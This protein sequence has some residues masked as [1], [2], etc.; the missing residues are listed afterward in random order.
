MT[1]PPTPVICACSLPLSQSPLE[2]SLINEVHPRIAHV[3]VCWFI[4]GPSPAAP[5]RQST[6][7]ARAA[8]IWASRY[9]HN[10]AFFSI[11]NII[12]SFMGHLK[13]T[14]HRV[15]WRVVMWMK[16]PWFIEF[17]WETFTVI[18][19][20]VL[21]FGSNIPLFYAHELRI[22]RLNWKKYTFAIDWCADLLCSL[23][24]IN[25]D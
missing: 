23:T 24:K 14:F 12:G 25:L 1:L 21:V 8:A 4:A 3:P 2:C 13:C 16:L 19:L 10:T 20:S 7:T 22:N 6:S 15:S 18:S 5:A 9:N 11:A 17:F